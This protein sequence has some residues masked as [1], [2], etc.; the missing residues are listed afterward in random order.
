MQIDS[1][2]EMAAAR[3]IQTLLLPRHLPQIAGADIDGQSIPAGAIGGDYLDAITAAS[4]TL[5][6]CI[7]DVMGKGLRAALLMLSLRSAFRSV[8]RYREE[9]GHIIEHL[10]LVAG[11]DLR[12]TGSFATFCLLSFDQ[13]SRRLTWSNAGHY[14]PLLFRSGQIT[15]LD[16]RGVALGLLEHCPTPVT[17][18][19]QLAPG[20]VVVLY[21]DGLLEAQNAL[22][23]KFGLSGL[24]TAVRQSAA[25]SAAG[26][27]EAILA[28]LASFTQGHEQ[29]DDVT[30][31]ILKAKEGAD[32][33]D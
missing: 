12:C 15:Y 9:H 3:E 10:H 2:S 19:R 28:S 1:L 8:L 29:R 20:D 33:G 16:G 18:T 21:T 5:F 25:L 4:G 27:K 11:E 30:M 32:L 24:E 23:A 14:P 13:S 26:I 6:L 22:G 7:A 31:V 17:Y